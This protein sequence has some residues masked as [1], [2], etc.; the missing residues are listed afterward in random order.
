MA[1]HHQDASPS[2]AAM[3]VMTTTDNA[4]TTA[5]PEEDG[6]SDDG[7]IYWEILMF[8]AN[9][10]YP[11]IVIGGCLS[12]FLGL[13]VMRRKRLRA[14]SVCVYLS[15]LAIS[16]SLV[17]ALDFINNWVGQTLGHNLIA[18]NTPLCVLYRYSFEVSLLIYQFR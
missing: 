9:Y 16:D 6:G 18:F 3:N 15:I 7:A 14:L 17:L 2:N 5:K 10:I 1:A 8:L 11:I 4:M 12:N 13:A